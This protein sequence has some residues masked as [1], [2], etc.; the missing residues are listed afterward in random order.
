MKTFENSLSILTKIIA[1]LDTKHQTEYST[2]TPKVQPN[3]KKM[4]IGDFIDE[5]AKER[6]LKAKRDDVI[7]NIE[8]VPFRLTYM[9][10]DEML[11]IVILALGLDE[12]A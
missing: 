8:D 12:L 10:D 9:K 1:A 2:V 5:L 3:G 4:T 11:P 6:L 7:A